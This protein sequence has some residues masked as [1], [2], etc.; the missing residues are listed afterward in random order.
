MA[1]IDQRNGKWRARYRDPSGASR[2]RT[3]SRK[4]DAQ[5]F[6][7]TV[8]ADK[9]RGSYVDPAAGRVTF[10]AFAGQWLAAQ[11]VD[12]KTQEGIA[13][14]L[15][16]HLLPAF[17]TVELRAIRPSSVQQ[18]M[19]GASRGL[20]PSYVRLLLSTLSAIL[21]AAVEDGVIV[22]NPC[23]S[24]AVQPPPMTPTRVVPWTVAQVTD[25]VD[26]LPER[27]RATAIVAA[28]CGLRQGEVFG[29][30]VD[31]VD[32]LRQRVEVRQQVKHV[33]GQGVVFCPPKRGKTR[34]V[35]LPET[36]AVALAEH[37]RVH[38]PGEDG[39]VF[40]N[41]A[42]GPI[43][44]GSFNN[45]A[46][47]PAVSAAGLV[48]DRDNGFHVLRHTYASVMLEAGV[49]IRALA[50]YLGHTDP[51]FTLRVYTHLMPASEDRAR[52]AVDAAF[53]RVPDVSSGV[54]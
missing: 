29:L 36:V 6:L 7:T 17:G 8:E 2:S 35:P 54:L 4:V 30:A 16:A 21:G 51:G 50:D 49:S 31:A 53:S 47:K 33:T 46:W 23:R 24:R 39:L 28:G 52:Q 42:G 34:T 20:A 38:P 37:L 1:S 9:L 25:A 11:T 22:K 18:W 27:Y 5:R 26:A 45:R 12:A 40:T 13:S 19:A 10:E 44:R 48:P 43:N 32:F 41:T 3:F 14:H 15:R